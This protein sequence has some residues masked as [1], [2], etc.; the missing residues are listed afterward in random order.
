MPTYL[1]LGNFTEQGIHNVKDTA[2][3]AEKLRAMAK[4]AGVTVREVYWTLGQYDIATIWEAPDESAATAL[5]LSVGALGNVRTTMLRAFT[6]DEIPGVL[7]KM[8]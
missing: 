8:V 4:K 7:E 6:A 1:V 2:K 3:R 5:A